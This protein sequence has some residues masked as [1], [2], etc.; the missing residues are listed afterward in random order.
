MI[1]FL[2][3]THYYVN[4]YN[5]VYYNTTKNV[6]SM[7][8]C[9]EEEEIRHQEAFKQSL[10]VD[11]SDYQDLSGLWQAVQ[12]GDGDPPEELHRSLA[13]IQTVDQKDNEVLKP[14]PYS[15]QLPLGLRRGRLGRDCLGHT[16]HLHRFA[17]HDP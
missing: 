13:F 8:T 16:R 1:S 7:K 14:H 5:K 2:I 4:K 9:N 10:S 15:S 3:G 17:Q 12:P 11:K 6:S